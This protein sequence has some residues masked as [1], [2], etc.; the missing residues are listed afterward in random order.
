[1]PSLVSIVLALGIV[2]IYLQSVMPPLARSMG[3]AEMRQLFVDVSKEWISID[4]STV[5]NCR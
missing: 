4:L 3:D 2:G 1:M 5:V